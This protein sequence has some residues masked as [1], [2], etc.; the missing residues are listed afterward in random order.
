MAAPCEYKKRET[1][2]KIHSYRM[3]EFRAYKSRECPRD[4]RPEKRLDDRVL[5]GDHV[6]CAGLVQSDGHGVG[7]LGGDVIG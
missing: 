4:E 2:H 3:S 6:W 5:V 7:P 1:L